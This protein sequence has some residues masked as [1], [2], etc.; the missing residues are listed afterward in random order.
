ML[1]D[2]LVCK[3]STD[4]VNIKKFMIKDG[5][6]KIKSLCTVCGKKS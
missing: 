4:N 6:L 1:F 5:R 2:C 3:K